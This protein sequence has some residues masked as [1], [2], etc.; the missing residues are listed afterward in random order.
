MSG[1]Q[2]ERRGKPV[3]KKNRQ[4]GAANTSRRFAASTAPILD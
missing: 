3:V 1:D 4:E 2:V